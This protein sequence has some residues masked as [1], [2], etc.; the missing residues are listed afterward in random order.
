MAERIGRPP[1]DPYDVI[2]Y[3]VHETD[4]G[5]ERVPVRVIDRI[6]DALRGNAFKHD[7]AARAG[8][9]TETLRAWQAKG[10]RALIELLAGRKRRSDFEVHTLRCMELA[11]E[12]ERAE[13]EARS[14]L[15]EV[16]TRVAMGG[17]E[18]RKTVERRDA[19][20][21]LQDITEHTEHTLPDTRTLTWLLTHRYREEFSDRL[22]LTG[23]GGGPVELNVSARDRLIEAIQGVRER[24]AIEVDEVDVEPRELAEGA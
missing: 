15:L 13:A 18:R 4:D 11:T 10:N 19:E 1:H 23:P 2:D 16:T 9:S 24:S 22:E 8:I 12:I 21:N 14:A 3:L 20:G 6:V 17:V 5:V 7:A